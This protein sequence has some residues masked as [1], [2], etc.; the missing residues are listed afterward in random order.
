VRPRSY[1]LIAVASAA[2]VL[3]AAWAT[4]TDEC[5]QTS[6]TWLTPFVCILSALS[7]GAIFAS[8]VALRRRQGGNIIVW[9]IQAAVAAAIWGVVGFFAVFIIVVPSHCLD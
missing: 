5:I 2:A 1:F 4:R 3:I 7:L 8:V 9:L 6:P